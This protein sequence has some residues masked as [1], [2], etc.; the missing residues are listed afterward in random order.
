MNEVLQPQVFQVCDLHID[1]QIHVVN[2][3]ETMRFVKTVGNYEDIYTNTISSETAK[4]FKQIDELR[5][6]KVR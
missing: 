3:F 6:N 1:S 5:K 2:C 4:M